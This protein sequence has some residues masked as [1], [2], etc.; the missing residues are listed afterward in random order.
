MIVG[1]FLLDMD[2]QKIFASSVS[3]AEVYEMNHIL[4]PFVRHICTPRT[5]DWHSGPIFFGVTATS[6]IL[7]FS[8]LVCLAWEHSNRHAWLDWRCSFSFEPLQGISKARG[9]SFIWSKIR[10][11]IQ[12]G[13][14][15]CK[16]S[17]LS[18]Q[19]R[20]NTTSQ[21][22][23]PPAIADSTRATLPAS[24]ER[25]NSLAYPLTTPPAA[26]GATADKVDAGVRP[27][28]HTL[29]APNMYTYNSNWPRWILNHWLHIKTL[30]RLPW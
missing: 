3:I 2:C 1:A 27:D 22:Y 18:S 16:F 26:L 11:N 7:A 25:T 21:N 24:A 14:G 17:V 10:R 9:G 5:G 12:G 20:I 30:N 4:H 19:L 6:A 13:S 15:I 8:I 28:W 29:I 23:K